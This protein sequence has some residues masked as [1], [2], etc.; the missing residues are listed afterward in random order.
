MNWDDGTG[1]NVPFQRQGP[2][3]VPLAYESVSGERW[4][5]GIVTLGSQLTGESKRRVSV[6]PA[7]RPSASLRRI[8]ERAKRK[9]R[10]RLKACLEDLE[11]ALSSAGDPILK[12]NSLADVRGHLQALWEMV[13]GSPDSEA[14]EEVVNMLQ[15]ALCVED[16]DV[17]RHAS[18]TPYRPFSTRC[19]TIRMWTTKRRM[20][21]LRN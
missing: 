1:G 10:R 12:A 7:T 8:P 6:A 13:E 19:T 4:A 18:W 17:L 16:P 11:R 14:F 9:R 5:P 20:I 2:V 21:S 15:I 3:E